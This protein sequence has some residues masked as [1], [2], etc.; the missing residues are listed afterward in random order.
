MAEPRLSETSSAFEIQREFG[1]SH[2][3]FF[4]IFPRIEPHATRTGDREMALARDDGRILQIELSAEMVRRLGALKIPFI[5]I[6]FR[7]FG[8]SVEQRA[9][10][11][12][13]FERAFQK[14]GG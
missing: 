3:D 14:G 8:W 13:K 12:K 4:R 5:D 10:F 9:E 2:S 1:L 11:F 6:T 7:F